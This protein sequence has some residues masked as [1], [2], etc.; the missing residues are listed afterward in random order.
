MVSIGA[1]EE[2]VPEIL[3]SPS[4]LIS[5]SGLKSRVSKVRCEFLDLSG[6]TES[7]TSTD[8][9][10]IMSLWSLFLFSKSV[11]KDRKKEGKDENL[12]MQHKEMF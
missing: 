8:F 6:L 9:R 12:D 11:W 4:V 2:G 1:V 5:L 3:G 10:M 7:C